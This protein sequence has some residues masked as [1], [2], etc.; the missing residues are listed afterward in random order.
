MENQRVRLSKAL[1]K[2]ALLTLLRTKPIEKITIYDICDIAQINRSTFYRYY[3]SQYELLTAVENDLFAE[4][5]KHLRE[6]EQPDRDGLTKVAEFLEQ[7]RD[8]CR[9]LINSAPEKEFCSK[10]FALPTVVS[11][12]KD[13][14]PSIYTAKQETYMR[15]FFCQGGYAIIREWLNSEDRESPGEIA[16]LI[17]SFG[18]RLTT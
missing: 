2:E 17:A 1:L 5:E 15:L 8:K 13:Y 7:E 9:V 14:T 11:M 3:G 16:A 12:L 4:I 10:L 6:R 18:K